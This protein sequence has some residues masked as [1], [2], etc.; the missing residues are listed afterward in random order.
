MAL[1]WGEIYRAGEGALQRHTA[2]LQRRRKAKNGAEK[3]GIG[4]DK[5]WLG[6]VGENAVAKHYNLYWRVTDFGSVDV[7]GKFEV[8]A[9]DALYKR[10]VLHKDDPD[11]LPFILA[12]VIP[13]KL[14]I[15]VLAGWLEGRE[16]KREEWWGD[17]APG[18][19]R[20]A[21]WVPNEKLHDVEELRLGRVGEFTF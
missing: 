20:P 21:Y 3:D 4:L 12:Y 9:T 11:D 2:N 7:G 15:V 18:K 19:G 17:C 6:C 10:L 8:R 5:H 13:E 16:G 14:P 1:T